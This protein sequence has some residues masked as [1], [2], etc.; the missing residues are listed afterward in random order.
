MR[1]VMIY[2]GPRMLLAHPVLAI[3]HLLDEGKDA[4]ARPR[5]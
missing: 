1:E 3:R 2:A 5:R 4:P